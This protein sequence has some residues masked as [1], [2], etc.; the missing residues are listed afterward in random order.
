MI[1]AGWTTV[2]S[3]QVYRRFEVSEHSMAP[4]LAPGDYLL[5]SRVMDRLMAG[6]IVVYEH[7]AQAGFWLVKRVVGLPGDEISVH[8]NRLSRNQTRFD[9][10]PTPGRGRWN[11]PPGTVF[12]A[13]DNRT[14]SSSDSRAIGP[15]PV[16]QIEG[17]V[18]F[19][20]WPLRALGPIRRRRCP[21]GNQR[22]RL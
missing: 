15:I 21:P 2:H 6:D 17:R 5:T 18:V 12:V 19:R 20:Y 11:V 10:L 3:A 8:N 22:L 13:G 1:L 14:A 4:T 7:P 9:D 16:G